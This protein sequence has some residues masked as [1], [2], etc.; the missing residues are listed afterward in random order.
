MKLNLKLAWH[1][2]TALA[3]LAPALMTTGCVVEK[4]G[5][6][7]G[8]EDV[9]IATPLGGMQ[10]KTND[11]SIAADIGLPVYPGAVVIKKDSGHDEGAA[12]VNMSFGNF[13]L[14]VKAVSYQSADA[15]D[16]VEAF[17]QTALQ[18]YGDV[19]QCHGNTAVGKLA[20]T[21]EG[22]TCDS[23]K[24][25]H[26]HVSGD[27]EGSKVEL[28]AGSEQHQHIVAIDPHDAGTKIGLIMLEL[29]SNDWDSSKETN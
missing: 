26:V 22:L 12:D 6:G 18:R 13:H 29:P 9:K 4:T 5:N 17:Y 3:L 19:I 8:S 21:S 15:P 7:K 27:T 10:V 23:D 28:K 25:K 20:K 16:K 2:A 11:S 1:A 14:R 24:G